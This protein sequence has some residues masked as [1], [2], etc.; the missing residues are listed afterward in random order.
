MHIHD[1]SI[2]IHTKERAYT[3]LQIL[4]TIIIEVD[5]YFH[6]LGA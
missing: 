6:L 1:T 2:F 5:L 4:H 3:H